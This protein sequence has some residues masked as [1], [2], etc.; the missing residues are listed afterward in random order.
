M[1]PY[2]GT[3][4][5]ELSFWSRFTLCCGRNSSALEAAISCWDTL[6]AAYI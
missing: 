6:L 2:V 3:I 5:Q 4:Q 1:S